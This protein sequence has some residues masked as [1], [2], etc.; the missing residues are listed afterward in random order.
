MLQPKKWW[1]GLPFL[2]ALVWGA[3]QALTP[4]MESELRARA[5]ARLTAQPE[6]FDNPQIVVSGRDL[7]I[8]GVALSAEAKDHALA[9]LRGAGGVRAV[10][11]ATSPLAVARPFALTLERRGR[12]ATLRGVAPV[13]GERASL[14]AA[15][16]A[17]G[18]DVDD[19]TSFAAGAP[20]VFHSLAGFAA[21]LLAALDP[22]TATLSDATLTL[23]GEARSAEDYEKAMTAVQAPPPGVAVAA[24]ILPPRISPYLFSATIGDGV[25]AIGGHLPTPEL[26]K[27]VV[28]Q[29]AAAGSGFAVSDAT[30]IGSGAPAGDYA[31]AVAVAFDA[32]AKLAHGKVVL[33]DARLIVEGQG[34]ENVDGETLDALKAR[35]PQGF[36]LARVDVAAGPVSPYVLSA[37]RAGDEVTLGGYAPDEAARRRV[38]DSARR[39]FFDARVA[40][41]V[42]IAKGAPANFVET[43]EGALAALARL[44]EGRLKIEGAL[45]SLS[46]AARYEAARADIERMLAESMPPGV[47]SDAMLTARVV[48]ATLDAEQCRDA[49]NAALAEGNI[50]FAGDAPTFLPRSAPVLDAIA[51]TALRCPEAPIDVATHPEGAGIE[52]VARAKAKRRAEAL[53][54]WLVKSGVDPDKLRVAA[55][56]DSAPRDGR[57]EFL[58]RPAP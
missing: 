40:G 53:V 13:G 11:D 57:V 20:T 3:A 8:G 51:A 16:A 42:K 49:L 19:G 9:D 54:A 31:A 45:V 4:A 26:R 21:Q 17:A 46:G 22:A 6:A 37:H 23:R 15:L 47:K 5:L 10:E 28:A 55:I 32:L 58:L 44:A 34:R 1:I 56:E 41:E 12:S 38:L 50:E 29:A 25:I 35:L 33:D 39:S 14:R 52:E 2:V 43:A 27:T 48:G 7:R 18:L 30:R 24:D 36:A